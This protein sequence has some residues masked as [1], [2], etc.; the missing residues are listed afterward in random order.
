MRFEHTFEEPVA[1]PHSRGGDRAEAICEL[2]GELAGA[3]PS[4]LVLYDSPSAER[5]DGE[6][7]VYGDLLRRA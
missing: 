5:R 3:K 4:W 6:C 2:P 1:L 7:T